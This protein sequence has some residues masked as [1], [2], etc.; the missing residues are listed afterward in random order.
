MLQ[1]IHKIVEAT[2]ADSYALEA[3]AK[4]LQDF[5]HIIRK[6]RWEKLKEPLNIFLSDMETQ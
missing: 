5:D 2:Y 1:P 6:A 4:Y 3:Y